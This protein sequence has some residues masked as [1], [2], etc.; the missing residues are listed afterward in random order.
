MLL[1]K[2]IPIE[3]SKADIL[4]YLGFKPLKTV[5]NPAVEELLDE[6]LDIARLVIAPVAVYNTFDIKEVDSDRVSLAG[7]KLEL[8]G[9]G[10]SRFMS[11]CARVSLIA[12]TIGDEIDSEIARLFKID[13]SSRAVMLDAAGSDAVEQVISWVDNLIQQ[14]ARKEGYSTL[15]RVSPGYS[16]W[17]LEGNDM[18]AKALDASKIGIEVLPS[19]EMLPRKSVMAAI[20]WVPKS[21]I[22]EADSG[23]A[24]TNADNG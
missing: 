14:E 12:A 4:S 20:G 10:I 24:D 15:H 6:V 5:S 7:T 21:I 22:T 16:L 17:S 11:S 19:F 13:N 1:V 23:A 3:F 18:I 9:R 2:N 8:K